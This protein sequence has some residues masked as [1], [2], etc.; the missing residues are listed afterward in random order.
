VHDGETML[1]YGAERIEGALPSKQSH[2]AVITVKGCVNNGNYGCT[3]E[4]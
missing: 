2:T 1:E 3:I 4:Q